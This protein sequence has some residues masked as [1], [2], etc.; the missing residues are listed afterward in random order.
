MGSAMTNSVIILRI[1][2]Q[3]A[4][5]NRYGFE[6]S[7]KE[8]FKCFTFW[9]LNIIT[10]CYHTEKLYLNKILAGK[11]G[12]YQKANLKKFLSHLAL[13]LFV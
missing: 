2:S 3:T 7:I 5:L 8:P 9:V 12:S 4:L 1:H 13:T 10:S 6:V 11:A